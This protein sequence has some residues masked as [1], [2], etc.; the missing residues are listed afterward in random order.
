MRI[1][2]IS[3]PWALFNR[4]SVQLGALKGYL[5]QQDPEIVVDTY[6]PY[7]EVSG[8]IGQEQYLSIAKNS[9]AGEAL[10]CGL[11][12]PEHREQ[13]RQLFCSELKKTA[14]DFAFLSSQ[15]EEHL[16]QWLG[17][18]DF[19]AYSLIGFSVCF[20]QLPASLL[21][22]KL[23]KKHYP[24]VPLVFGGSTC[25]QAMGD[26]LVSTFDSLDFVIPG[27]GEKTLLSLCHHLRDQT[28]YPAHCISRSQSHEK[29]KSFDGPQKEWQLTDLNQLPPPDYS[30]Y[31]Q[32]MARQK[33]T[34]IPS[35]PVEFSRGCWWNKCSFCNLNLQWHGYRY[36][37]ADTMAAEIDL[38]KSKH[39][40][41]DFFFTDNALPKSEADKFFS[42]AAKQYSGQHYFA[43]IRVPERALQYGLYKEGGLSSVQIGIEA[44]SNSLLNKMCKGTSVVDNIFALKTALENDIR[45]DG[46]LILEFPGSTDLEVHET[47]AA[48]D[49]I[50]PYPPLQAAT[51]FLG[52]G[53]P[54]HCQPDHYGIKTVLQHPK[55]RLLYPRKVIKRLD[56]LIKSYRGDKGKQARRW[57]PV[58]EKIASWHS[59]HQRRDRNQPAL[60]LRDGKDFLLIRQERPG[61]PVLRHRLKGLSRKI[62]LHC[63]QP[64]T[65]KELLQNFNHVK[66]EQLSHF[67]QDLVNK[68]L[69][70][71]DQQTYLALAIFIK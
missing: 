35:L 63:C 61:Q 13:T 41:L 28:V 39:Q 7:L 9:W 52:Y 46:N 53:S 31:F 4:P 29:E 64:V 55:N 14:A 58:R 38:L 22:T 12:F 16:H 19:S 43:E 27:E 30:D 11:L 44:L 60:S 68:H 10:Y 25:T 71:N 20:S 32:E 48:L 17:Q 37:S 24:A 6:H 57:H 51:F 5:H 54:A 47:L 8:R 69:L 26:S 21:A 33:Y 59:F 42:Q 40:C 2:L 34:F 15:L 23:L 67:L 49:K 45:V 65:R 50:L 36:K 56:L 66:E 3:M 1:A 18:T 62:Y 70:Y